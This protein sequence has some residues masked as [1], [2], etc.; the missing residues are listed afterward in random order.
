MRINST[1]LGLLIFFLLI[2]C[3]SK[4]GDEKPMSEE[5]SALPYE[6][7]ED[8][9]SLASYYQLEHIKEVTLR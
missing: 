1:L 7:S 2:D 8:K 9:S 5:T 6:V 4:K 3:S